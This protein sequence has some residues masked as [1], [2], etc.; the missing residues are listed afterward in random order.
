MEIKRSGTETKGK[1]YV[2]ND[3]REVALMTYSKAGADEII[4]DHTEVDAS[5]KGRG[6]G[7][8]LVAE[9]VKFARENSLKI[10]PRCP[11]AQAEFDKHDDYAD[12]LAD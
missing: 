8:N 6:I 11:F 2:E 5:L 4:I 7:Q 9:G 3:G 1:F 10:I 12:V